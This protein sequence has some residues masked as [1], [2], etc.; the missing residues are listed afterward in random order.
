MKSKTITRFYSTTGKELSFEVR[1][2]SRSL[3]GR[4]DI[5]SGF[6]V[7]DICTIDMLSFRKEI[8]IILSICDNLIR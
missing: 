2:S 8:D 3:L 6:F 7:I 1:Y 5:C 4:V